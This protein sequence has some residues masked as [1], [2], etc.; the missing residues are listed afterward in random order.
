V[1]GVPT[2]LDSGLAGNTPPVAILQGFENANTDEINS[3]QQQVAVITDSANL[4]ADML[5]S[6][7]VNTETTL[8]GLQAEQ[9]SLASFLKSG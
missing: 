6:E 8:A 9:A 2:L 3:I 1:T 7:F 5:R 4:Q